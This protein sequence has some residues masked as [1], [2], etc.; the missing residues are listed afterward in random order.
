[1]AVARY[2][3]SSQLHAMSKRLASGLPPSD[4]RAAIPTGT[5]FHIVNVVRQGSFTFGIL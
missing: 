3:R 5:R 2:P 1:M 4:V